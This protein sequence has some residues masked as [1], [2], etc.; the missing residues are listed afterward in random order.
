MSKSTRSSNASAPFQCEWRASR[1]C[2]IGLLMLALLAAFAILQAEL[3]AR[4]AWPLAVLACGVGLRDAH[5][6]WRQPTQRV[7]IPSRRSMASIDGQPVHALRV[8]WRGPIAFLCWRDPQG[9]QQRRVFAP[10]TLDAAQR[11][12]LRLAMQRRESVAIAASVAK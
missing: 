7:C 9:R 6:Y 5:R 3:P 10:D 12:E 2:A 8:D 4:M 11:R 1:H